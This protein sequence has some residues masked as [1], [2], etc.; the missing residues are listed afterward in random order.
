MNLEKS[1]YRLTGPDGCPHPVLDTPY[2][3]MEA[4]LMAAKSWCDGQGA[5]SPLGDRSIGVE[6]KTLSGTWRTVNYQIDHL[7]PSINSK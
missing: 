6:V 2:E 5:N 4:A 1:F 7:L 3:S